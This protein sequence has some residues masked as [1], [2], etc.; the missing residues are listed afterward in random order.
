MAPANESSWRAKLISFVS[1]SSI[2]DNFILAAIVLNSITIACVDYEHVDIKYQPS[3][4]SSPRNFII[5]KAEYVF[6]FI[7][8]CEC[9]LKCAAYGLWRGKQ[10]YFRDGWNVLDFCIVVVS[11]LGLLPNVP[12]FTM[13]RSFRVLRPLR[14]ISKLPNLRRIVIGF[15]NSLPELSNVLVL[16]LFILV[17]FALLGLTFWRGLFHSRCRLTPYP[18]KMPLDCRNAPDPCWDE[19]I[20]DAVSH[21]EAYRCLS[22]ENDDPQ[23]L[24]D[25]QDCIW[26]IDDSDVR[27]CSV[28]EGGYH[29]CDEQVEFMAMN[30]SRTCGSNYINGQPRFITSHEPYGFPRMQNDVF[31][32]EF[33]WGFTNFDD[34]GA[35]FLT[36]FQIVTMEGWSS[37]MYRTMDSWSS[38]PTVISYVALILIGSQ[39]VLNIML[40]V[41]SNSLDDKEDRTKL[42][43]DNMTDTDGE[44]KTKRLKKTQSILI[45]RIQWIVA[46]KAYDNAMLVVIVINTIILSC[47][48]HGIS[49]TFLHVLDAGN[50]FTTL[51]FCL[52]MVLCNLSLGLWEYWSSPATFF[53]G[54]IAIASAA[55]LI[56][57]RAAASGNG[58]KSVMSVFRSLRLVRLFKMIQSWKS[59]HSLLNTISRAAADVRSFGVLLHFD[60]VTGVHI[61]IQ[62]PRYDSSDIPRHNFDDLPTALVT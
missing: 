6:T 16:L 18:I 19:F 55:E 51:V 58:G 35:A 3:T 59:L 22:L 36:S 27:V 29:G 28:L 33:N 7:F 47:D 13:L 38:A 15:I 54:T 14:S 2:F 10:A 50:F 48:H 20:L 49:T 40:A 43:E 23:W 39:L 42:T 8:A 17:G 46:S 57:T 61:D 56:V 24:R 34:F 26:P 53:D 4:D 21:P 25:P 37:I 62:D 60:P 9:I 5:E 30:V 44:T 12:N 32:S 45:K 41:I 1:P 52:D 31:H 11:I